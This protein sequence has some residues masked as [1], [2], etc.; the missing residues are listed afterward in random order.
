MPVSPKFSAKGPREEFSVDAIDASEELT[1]LEPEST[2]PAPHSEE[3]QALLRLCQT[4]YL[5]QIADVNF[6]A[7]RLVLAVRLRIWFI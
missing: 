6:L 4:S 3:L 7:N 5:L 1:A 2:L